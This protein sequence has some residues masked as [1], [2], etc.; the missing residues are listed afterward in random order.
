MPDLQVL[1]IHQARLNITWAGNNGDYPD[2]VPFDISDGE[3]RNIAAEAIRTGYVPGIQADVRVNLA[4]FVVDRFG[5]TAEVPWNRIF[6]RPK[7][8]FGS[9]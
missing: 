5:A 2:P 6:L 1:H 7:T 3:I 4:D 8:P 9:R